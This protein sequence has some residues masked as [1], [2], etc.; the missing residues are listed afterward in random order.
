MCYLI[1]IASSRAANTV[2]L[3]Y[4]TFKHESTASN[5]ARIDGAAS[6]F[7][8]GSNVRVLTET[9]QTDDMTV[10]ENETINKLL[11]F[12]LASLLSCNMGSINNIFINIF[13]NI[14]KSN[15]VV[16][17]SPTPRSVY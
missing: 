16:S 5:G 13:I 4:S 9:I 7:M 10:A 12:M 1:S 14:H 3:E 6:R 8:S 15:W 11:L 2:F 17:W